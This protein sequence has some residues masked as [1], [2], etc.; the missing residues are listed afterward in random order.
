MKGRKPKP[1]EIKRLNGNP[2]KRPLPEITLIG[3]RE[4]PPMP[5]RLSE[6]AKEAWMEVVP[7]LDQ[8]GILDAVDGATL[9]ALCNSIARMRQLDEA[10]QGAPLMVPGYRG[11]ESDRL[12]A[13]TRRHRPRFVG[14]RRRSDWTPP[15]AHG[16]GSA[17]S[18]GARLTRS[19]TSSS[20]V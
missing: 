3:G 16:S 9:E 20:D 4:A 19:S 18:A 15:L 11:S 5:D 17:R 2:G 10:L 13:S 8:A 14:G 7:T 6:G 12:S 1:V